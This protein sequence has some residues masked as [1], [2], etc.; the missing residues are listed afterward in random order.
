M[1]IWNYVKTL[2]AFKSGYSVLEFC[3]VY[4]YNSNNSCNTIW[5][6]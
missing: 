1:I 2:E 6:Q 5:D 3:H 4:I